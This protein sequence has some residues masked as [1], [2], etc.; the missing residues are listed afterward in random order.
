MV[1]TNSKPLALKPDWPQAAERWAAFWRSEVPEDRVLM[2]IRVPRTDNPHPMPPVPDDPIRYHTDPDFFMQ[3]QLHMVY[4][5]EYLAEAFP[6]CTNSITAAY[7]GILLGGRLRPMAD[8]VIHSEPFVTDWA[9]VDSIVVD[10]N[11]R[12]YEVSMQQLDALLEHN[13]EFLVRIP[14]FHTVSDALVAIRGGTEL[15]LDLYDCPDRIHWASA[16][17]L[18]AWKDAY[19]EVYELLSAKQAGSPVWLGMWHPGRM[20]VIQE[21]FADNLSPAQYREFFM[22]YDR[23]LARYVDAALFHLHNT[24]IRFQEVTLDMPEVA[25]SQFRTP[26]RPSDRQPERLETELPLFRRLQEAGKKLWI[27]FLDEDEI[28]TA[29]MNGDPRHLFLFGAA[30]DRDEAR[31]LMDTA[32][33]CTAKRKAELGL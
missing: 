32:A 22:P 6:A 30:A 5:N 17:I 16:R 9:A 13:D 21:D 19:D 20:E 23:A 33:E 11:S 29:I 25:G 2:A 10:R 18:E 27:G 24:M 14:D 15:A 1:Q 26:Y 12:W 3:R 4:A 8:G 28:R 7:L 31:R